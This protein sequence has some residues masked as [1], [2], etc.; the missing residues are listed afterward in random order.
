MRRLV[1]LIFFLL[2]GKWLIIPEKSVAQVDI[3]LFTNVQQDQLDVKVRANSNINAYITNI[4]FT[5]KWPV[6]S[7]FSLNYQGLTTPFELIP[8]GQYQAGGYH[9]WVFVSIGGNTLNMPAG[10][11]MVCASFSFTQPA[12]L[13]I[14][15]AHDTWTQDNNGDY[16]FELNGLDNTGMIY[17]P[18]VTLNNA[19]APAGIISGTDSVCREN[20]HVYSI[21]PL[22]NAENYLWN[23]SG[24]GVTIIGDSTT[25]TIAFSDVASSGYLTV[26]GSNFCGQGLISPPLY[27]VVD[28]VPQISSTITGPTSVCANSQPVV[29]SIPAVNQPGIFHWLL[30]PGFLSSGGTSSNSLLVSFGPGAQS[31]IIKVYLSNSCGNSDTSQLLVGITPVPLAYAGM[32]TLIPYGNVALLSAANPGTSGYAFHWSPAVKVVQPDAQAT[33]TVSLYNTTLFTLTVVDTLSQCGSEDTKLVS[34]SGGPLSALPSVSDDTIC[35]GDSIQLFA[36]PCCGTGNYSYHWFTP[37]LN[38]PIFESGLENPWFQPDSNAVIHLIVS[39]GV[40]T[41]TSELQ[42]WVNPLPVADLLL[43][44]TIC[45]SDSIAVLINLSGTPPF[46]FIL[47]NNNVSYSLLNVLQNSVEVYL[48]VSGVYHIENLQDANCSGYSTG[49]AA[50]VV[51]PIPVTPFI[52]INGADLVSNYTLGNQWYDANGPIAGAVNQIFTPTVNGLYYDVITENGCSSL[53]SNTINVTNVGV[54]KL[55][56]DETIRLFP[57]PA[58]D[59]LFVV[60]P[61]FQGEVVSTVISMTGQILRIQRFNDILNGEFMLNISGLTP[62]IYSLQLVNH[63]KWSRN[64]LFL[65]Q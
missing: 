25:V 51:N 30:P 26:A 21:L 31:G 20:Q 34:L 50:L 64:L 60:C 33:Q 23:Y 40:S 2:L 38:S 16:Y 18:S 5:L 56:S 29:Y 27:I 57:N 62:G 63:A 32:D 28:S 17:Q 36:N 1:I 11:E 65:V 46:S 42:I 12:C 49:F 55:N 48:T 8:Q 13:T 14:E 4:Q 15:I 59:F 24:T 7:N 3:G 10:A 39:D 53:P 45:Q 35:S 6:Q 52:S 37:D 58:T 47:T 44:D 9:Y 61:S 19:V 41:D 22:L 54:I 43:V